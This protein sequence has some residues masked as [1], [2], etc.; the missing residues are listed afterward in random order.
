MQI[1]G[2]LRDLVASVQFKKCEKHQWRSVNF[3]KVVG[4]KINTPPWVYKCTNATK[5]RNASHI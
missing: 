2:A 3:S 5:L 1:C 4:S